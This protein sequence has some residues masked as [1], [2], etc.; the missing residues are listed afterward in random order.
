MQAAGEVLRRGLS[1]LTLIGNPEDIEAKAKQ[2]RVD[3]SGANVV[4]PAEAE[5]LEK[6]TDLLYGLRKAKVRGMGEW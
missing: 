4:F 3:L 5:D 2:L 1:K 6:Y